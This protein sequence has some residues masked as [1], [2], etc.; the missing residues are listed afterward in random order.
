MSLKHWF[1][2]LFDIAALFSLSLLTFSMLNY[3]SSI[4]R[5]MLPT[6]F[7]DFHPA[8]EVLNNVFIDFP[9][10]FFDIFYINFVKNFKRYMYSKRILN[11]CQISSVINSGWR[12][13]DWVLHSHFMYFYIIR[14]L[15]IWKTS[16][17]VL[18]V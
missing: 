3:K 6:I 11:Q 14:Y 9:G 1:W 7:A 13:Y 10:E 12:V 5:M 4:K 2:V 17:C 18:S 16:T 8:V 15:V